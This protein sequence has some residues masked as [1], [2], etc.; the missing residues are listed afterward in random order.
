MRRLA[1]LGR[2]L[3]P[4]VRAVLAAGGDEKVLKSGRALLDE[5]GSGS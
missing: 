1:K 5:L 4:K 2:F 3:E